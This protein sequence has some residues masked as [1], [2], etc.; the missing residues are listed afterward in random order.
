[1]LGFSQVN[2]LGEPVYR[3]RPQLSVW[4]NMLLQRDGP[5]LGA[6]VSIYRAIQPDTVL[7]QKFESIK[8]NRRIDF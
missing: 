4:N 2:V 6:S 8:R 1:M 3:R 5:R 7:G